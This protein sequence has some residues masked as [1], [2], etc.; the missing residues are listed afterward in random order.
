M[1]RSKTNIPPPLLELK[2]LDAFEGGYAAPRSQP[3]QRTEADD[4]ARIEVSAED[5]LI[6][7]DA[8]WLPQ[9]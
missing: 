9:R 2:N 7:L 8:W 3:P 5:A 6:T 1:K 4:A